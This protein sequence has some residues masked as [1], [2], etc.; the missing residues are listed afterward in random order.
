MESPHSGDKDNQEKGQVAANRRWREKY[1]K[2]L[3]DHNL[4]YNLRI[5]I[6]R[7]SHKL[8]ITYRR[9]ALSADHGRGVVGH[10]LRRLRE[11][12]NRPILEIRIIR[13]R[14]RL[15]QIEDGEKRTEKNTTNI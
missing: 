8:W 13:K 15:Q 10:A 14:D 12:W 9:N 1:K 2:Q 6:Y 11:W 3:T 5:S 7:K 4:R